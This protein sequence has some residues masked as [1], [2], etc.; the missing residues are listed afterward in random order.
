M[1]CTLWFQLIL[2]SFRWYVILVGH[3]PKKNLIRNPRIGFS[4]S[5][6]PDHTLPYLWPMT[7]HSC[8][9]W[10]QVGSAGALFV[11][12]FR[13]C[14]KLVRCSCVRY[15]LEVHLCI[16]PLILDLLWHELFSDFLFF[17]GL[18]LSRVGPCLIVGFSLFSPLFA[19]SVILL[20]FLPCHSTI[21]AVVLF[22]PF[23][24]GLFWA[25]YM[26]FSQLVTMTQHGYWIYTHATLGFLD[27][28]HCLWAP[29]AHFFLLGHPRSTF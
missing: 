9:G 20:P 16:F 7:H 18:P 29:L 24:L 12:H 14:Q 8:I 13:V 3:L 22:D 25:C 15:G 19:P 21:H 1:A 27:P 17:I 11:L 23:F 5:P 28:L 6:S 26:F 2:P 4:F 10:V